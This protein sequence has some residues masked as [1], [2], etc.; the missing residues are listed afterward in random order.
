MALSVSDV[1]AIVAKVCTRPDVLDACRRGDLG[2]VIAVLGT[3]K[4][5]QG[6]ISSLTGIPQGRLS[7]YKTGTRKP[8]ASST[9]RDFADGLDMPPAARTALGLDPEQSGSPI[10]A[11]KN[12]SGAPLL[13]VG[14]A[15]PDRPLETA[16][17]LTLLWRSDL[18]GAAP[19][20]KPEPQAWNDASLRWLIDPGHQVGSN[21]ASGVRI[22]MSDVERF[23]ATVD[24]FTQLD[25][26]F[27]GG[28]AEG[29]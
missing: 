1:R 16:D 6:K 13:D 14:L 18:G 5:T 21:L 8:Q 26:R 17:T 11:G 25:D 28:H 3:H 20:G 10:A 23:R 27:G 19:W 29:H 9:Y 7:E 12:A 22:G 2:T 4:V 24:M 15:Y